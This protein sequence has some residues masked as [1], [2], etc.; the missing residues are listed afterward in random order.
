MHSPFSAQAFGKACGLGLA[1]P[2]DKANF[3]I[4]VDGGVAF[5]LQGRPRPD[6]AFHLHRLPKGHSV[7]VARAPPSEV[8]DH[9]GVRDV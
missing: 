2:L 5:D 4:A 3:A 6:W 1:A 9:N 7:G 8:V